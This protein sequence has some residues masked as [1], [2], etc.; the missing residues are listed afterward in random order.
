MFIE[1]VESLRCTR[2]HEE[3]WLVAAAQRTEGRDIVTGTLGCPICGS[4]YPIVDGIADFATRKRDPIP[5]RLESPDEAMRLA[6]TLDLADPNGFAILTGDWG[7]H[8][9]DL[10]AIVENQLLLVNPP[11]DVASGGGVSIL[12]MDDR[13]PIARGS[14][15]AAAIDSAHADVAKEVADTVRSGGR[16]IGPASLPLPEG[17]RELAR[18]EAVWVAEREL[19]ATS[20]VT[21]T[22]RLRRMP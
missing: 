11:A 8:A 14:A 16:V 10:A 5:S 6:A 20:P 7:A 15:R 3:T 12:R 17:L 9:H 19:S 21:L 4:E 18:D 1:L 13:L 22:P 2:P